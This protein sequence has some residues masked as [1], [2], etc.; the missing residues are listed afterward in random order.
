MR[1]FKESSDKLK[2]LGDLG[3]WSKLIENEL[4]VLE[5][6]GK[7]VEH[8]AVELD[9][10]YACG[11]G[12]QEHSSDEDDREVERDAGGKGRG[13]ARARER[14]RIESGREG[15]WCGDCGRA[16][17]AAC[18]RES[19][20]EDQAD[21]DFKDNDKSHDRQE[22]DDSVHGR[23]APVKSQSRYVDQEQG[24]EP[25]PSSMFEWGG[26]AGGDTDAVGSETSTISQGEGW[27]CWECNLK[28]DLE[29]IVDSLGEEEFGVRE[30][31]MGE[32]S[33]DDIDALLNE[34]LGA[35]SIVPKS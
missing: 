24:R 22:L 26:W 11:E 3:N 21:Q 8:G 27:R 34:G 33:F 17:H 28:Y 6:T 9:K 18:A 10:C 25:K 15:R 31:G 13:K 30:D 32:S 5:E 16:W 1:L 19:D 2:S 29:G 7:I 12:I 23:S 20:N 4:D 35:P 14:M